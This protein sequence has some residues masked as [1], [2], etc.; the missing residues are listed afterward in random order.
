MLFLIWLMCLIEEER[1]TK[2]QRILCHRLQYTQNQAFLAKIV[3][4][5]FWCSCSSLNANIF[6][7]TIHESHYSCLKRNRCSDRLHLRNVFI[8]PSF[9]CSTVAMNAT[10]NGKIGIWSSYSTEINQINF[11]CEKNSSEIGKFIQ[12]CLVQPLNHSTNNTK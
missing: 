11:K 8:L 7:I 1:H 4:L 2:Y 10:L 5:R 12:Y 3:Y 9:V 6:I